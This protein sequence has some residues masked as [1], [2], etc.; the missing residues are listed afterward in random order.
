MTGAGNPARSG[1]LRRPAGWSAAPGRPASALESR[2][3]L[4]AQEFSVG[5]CL[6]PRRNVIAHFRHL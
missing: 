3:P 4:A 1:Y 5:L 2:Q 6:P